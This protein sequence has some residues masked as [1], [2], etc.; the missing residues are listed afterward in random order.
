M[1][2]TPLVQSLPCALDTYK[3][4]L[5]E[6]IRSHVNSVWTGVVWDVCI[7]LLHHSPLLGDLKFYTEH[8]GICFPP[9]Q[10]LSVR[11]AVCVCVCVCGGGGWVAELL[12]SSC[13][14]LTSVLPEDD[15]V[16]W[17]QCY[18]WQTKTDLPHSFVGLWSGSISWQ[19]PSEWQVLVLV[20]LL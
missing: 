19:W 14:Y 6:N 11:N 8:A 13:Q 17:L 15:C 9:L 5:Y 1:K 12:G 3:A 4:V 2:L 7:L 20:V 10:E 16:T 18:I